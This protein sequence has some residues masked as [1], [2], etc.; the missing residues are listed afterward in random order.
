MELY[1]YRFLGGNPL[2]FARQSLGVCDIALWPGKPHVVNDRANHRVNVMVNEWPGKSFYRGSRLNNPADRQALNIVDCRSI[3]P[4][5]RRPSVFTSDTLASG[6][7]PIGLSLI[8]YSFIFLVPCEF[9]LEHS[10]RT[11]QWYHPMSIPRESSF[12]SP[13]YATRTESYG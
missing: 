9:P 7:F 8:A 10:R 12:V 4:T 3:R 13:L 2:P 6:N 1:P 5:G 11:S